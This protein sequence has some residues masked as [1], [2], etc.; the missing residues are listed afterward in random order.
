MNMNEYI[1]LK[2]RYIVFNDEMVRRF[3]QQEAFQEFDSQVE[4]FCENGYEQDN[5]GRS[6]LD[7]PAEDVHLVIRSYIE[8]MNDE[9]PALCDE[10]M[11]NAILEVTGLYC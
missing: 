11:R 5:D 3:E 1:A 8:R 9:L 6:I 4:V 10:V 2:H 7:I